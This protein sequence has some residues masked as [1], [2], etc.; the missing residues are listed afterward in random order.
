MSQV[1]DPAAPGVVLPERVALVTG[2]SRGIGAVTAR[3]LAAN[4]YA[5]C[6]LARDG[7]AAAAVAGEIAAVGGLAM[8]R[9]VDVTQ[10]ADV[11]DAVN[12][13]LSTWGW[14]DLLVNSAGAI[15]R[16]VPVWEADVDQWWSVITTNVRGPF[17]MTRAVVPYMIAAGGGRI[18]NL[19][20]GAGMAERAELSAYCASKSALARVTGSTHQG[21]LALGIRAFDLAPG[22]VRTEMTLSMDLHQGRTEWTDPADVTDLVLALAGGELDAWSG[23]FVR[24]GVDTPATLREQARLGLDDNAR[25]LRLRP[26]GPSDPLG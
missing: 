2:A 7:A 19:N 21:G 18:I 9:S 25:T 26:W 6:L 13:V 16:E 15:E 4:G 23:R 17:L 1:P 24:A 3:A 14:I 12:A 20:S 5:V 11:D 8:A 22:T 10:E